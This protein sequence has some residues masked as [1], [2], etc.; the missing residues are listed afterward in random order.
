MQG[1]IKRKKLDLLYHYLTGWGI[2]RIAE[3]DSDLDKGWFKWLGTG[4]RAADFSEGCRSLFS[5]MLYPRS[6]ETFSQYILK[7]F[8][9]KSPLFQLLSPTNSLKQNKTHILDM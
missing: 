4:V 6:S 9:G 5:E 1:I 8:L 2:L 7:G 3:F